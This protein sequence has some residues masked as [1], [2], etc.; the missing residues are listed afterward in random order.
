MELSC[1]LGGVLKRILFDCGIEEEIERVEGRQV[2]NE[3]HLDR[4]L[5]RLPWKKH[6]GL[7]IRGSVELP[8][9]CVVW[10]CDIQRV[11]EN[12]SAAMQSG[13]QSNDLR[14]Q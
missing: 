4:E 8:Q 10:R 9:E 2:R 3:I 11:A 12:R 5:A 13:T 1:N 14:A 6:S 7:L